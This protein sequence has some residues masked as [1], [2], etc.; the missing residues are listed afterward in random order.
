MLLLTFVW[1]A[2]LIGELVWGESRALEIS[3][4]IV[5]Y[6]RKSGYYLSNHRKLN[7]GRVP[8]TSIHCF[9]KASRTDPDASH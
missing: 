4:T 6:V 1:L 7:R 5:A 8:S 3:G 9:P 2:L